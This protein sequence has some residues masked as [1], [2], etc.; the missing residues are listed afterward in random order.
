VRLNV[1]GES[2]KVEKTLRRCDLRAAIPVFMTAAEVNRQLEHEETEACH[3][4]G[5]Q[6]P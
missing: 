1:R 6:L 2:C 5:E 4:A 3:A